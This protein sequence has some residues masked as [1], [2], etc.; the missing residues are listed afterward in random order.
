MKVVSK[1]FYFNDDFRNQKPACVIFRVRK[2]IVS[3]IIIFF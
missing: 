1:D 3:I 2:K